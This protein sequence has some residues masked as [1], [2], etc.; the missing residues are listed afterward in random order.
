MKC[1]YCAEE[2]QDEARLC[3]FCGAWLVNG[4]WQSPA[5]PAFAAKPRRSF[6]MLTT[7]WLLIVSGVWMVV[8]CGSPV[9]L[10]GAVRTGAVAVLYNGVFGVLLLAMGY[11]LAGR[12]PWALKATAAATAAYTLDKVLFIFDSP[13]RL[14][15][16][17]D[18]SQLL[19]SLGPGMDS[20]VDQV[21]VVMAASFLAGWWGLV[22]YIYLKRGYFRQAPSAAQS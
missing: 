10:F 17:K 20:M 6:T 11:A 16:L 18:G 22:L 15:S 2:I 9:P 5:A 12:K 14:A 3:R 19:N 4:Q 8:M 1:P 13:A 7:G 21:A